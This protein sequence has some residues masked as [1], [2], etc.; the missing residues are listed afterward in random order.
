LIRK[1]K[2]LKAHNHNY[3]RTYPISYNFAGDSSEPILT[4]QN[5]TGYNNHTD[6]TIFALVGTG[7]ESFYPLNGHASYVSS[8]FGKFGLL[9][10]GISNGNP[11]TTLTGTFYDNKG[12][13]V[14]DQFTIGKEI[15]NTDVDI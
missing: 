1:S 2:V 14:L 15:I 8:Q 6:D 3:Q 4:N 7:G 5:T 9:Y 11:H 12:D 10:I 13:E